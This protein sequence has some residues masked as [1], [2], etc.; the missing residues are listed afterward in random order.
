[1]SGQ[2]TEDTLIVIIE[3]HHGLNDA[4]EEVCLP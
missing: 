4:N 3:H 2:V 1:M